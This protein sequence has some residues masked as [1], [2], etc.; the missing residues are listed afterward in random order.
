MTGSFPLNLRSSSNWCGLPT[1]RYG[2]KRRL[3]AG[4]LYLSLRRTRICIAMNANRRRFGIEVELKHKNAPWTSQ[5]HFYLS[6][7]DVH[8]RR[9]LVVGV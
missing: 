8:G 2:R 4:S 3:G 6:I 5:H 9:N 1:S 7:S